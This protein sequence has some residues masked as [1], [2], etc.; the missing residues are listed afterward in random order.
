MINER[1]KEIMVIG[2]IMIDCYYYGKVSRLSPE[3]SAPIFEKKGKSYKLGGAGKVVSYLKNANQKVAVASIVGKDE[4]GDKIIS[5]LNQLECNNMVIQSDLR[6]TTLKERYY[7]TYNRTVFRVDDE[8]NEEI[9]LLSEKQLI[10]SFIEKI[11]RFSVIIVS[12]YGK[13]VLTD[14]ILSTIIDKA[15][16]YDIK[17]IVDPKGTKFERYIGSY[18][19]KPNLK[20]LYDLTGINVTSVEDIIYAAKVLMEKCKTNY[21]LVTEGEHGMT[22]VGNNKVHHFNSNA[23]NV[24]DVTGAGDAV[25]SYL[26]IGLLNG[27]SIEKAVYIANSAAGVKVKLHGDE[28]IT[29]YDVKKQLAV[30]DSQSKIV[31]LNELLEDIKPV[32]DRKIVFTN[33]CFDLFHLGHLKCLEEASHLGDILIIA[34][35]SDESIKKLKG[36]NRPIIDEKHRARMLSMLPFVDYIVLFNDENLLNIIKLIKPDVLVKGGDYSVDEIVGHQFIEENDGVTV[37]IPVVEGVSTTKIIKKIQSLSNTVD[38]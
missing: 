4:N 17:V 37:C 1:T 23:E 34:I 6:K 16:S 35:N 15:R 10:D 33:G 28:D 20:E 19:I 18:L 2:D 29:I 36:N 12:D 27:L 13:G 30:K 8:S 7:D 26:S 32:R 21:V 5:L 11:G 38:E 31:S 25:I 3:S 22:L 24:C 9:D 14:R